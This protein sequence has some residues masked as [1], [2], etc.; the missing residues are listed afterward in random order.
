M[1]SAPRIVCAAIR[2]QDGTVLVGIRHYS[3]DMHSQMMA[4]NDG[5][6]FAHRQ[7]DDQGF[8]DQHGNYYTRCEAMKVAIEQGQLNDRKRDSFGRLF[9]EDLY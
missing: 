5:D 9:S 7:G 8:V 1:K 2:A 3:G 4:R 6:K